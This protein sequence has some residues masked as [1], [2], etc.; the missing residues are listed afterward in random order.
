LVRSCCDRLTPQ[1]ADGLLSAAQKESVRYGV[2][3]DP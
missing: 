2:H 3:T 1:L